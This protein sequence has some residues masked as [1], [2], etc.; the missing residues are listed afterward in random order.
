MNNDNFLIYHHLGLG[1]HITLSP[2]VRLI[3]Q[4]SKTMS[5]VTK[6]W[7]ADNVRFLYR[8]AENIKVIPCQGDHEAV[9]I[10]QQ[11][12]GPKLNHMYKPGMQNDEEGRFF[13]IK[14]QE[15]SRIH[16]DRL[17]EYF[18]KLM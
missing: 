5:V 17:F 1:D 14:T 6:E 10:F 13:N 12:E 4:Q 15:Y 3:A 7:Y 8:D 9:A 11:W 18:K 2:L 16:Q